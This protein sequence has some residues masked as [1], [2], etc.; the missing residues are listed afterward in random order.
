MKGSVIVWNIMMKAKSQIVGRL[1][2]AED[3]SLLL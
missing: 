3:I 2:A 1:N